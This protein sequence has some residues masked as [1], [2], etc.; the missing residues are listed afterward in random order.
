M[1]EPVLPRT[2]RVLVADDHPVVRDGTALILETEPDLRVVGQAADGEEA[3]RLA[4]ELRPEVLLL[5]LGMPRMDGVEVIRRLRET[6]PEINVVVFTVFDS[7]ERIIAALQAG[8]RG[9]LLKGARREELFDAVRTVAGGGSLL[10]PVVA[11][12]LLRHM[13]GESEEPPIEPLSERQLTVLQLVA[14]GLQNKEIA[15]RL[16]ISERTAKFH[17]ETVLR[18]LGATNRTEAAAIAT[19]RHLIEP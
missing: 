1:A 7:D 13:R 10:P 8:A 15:A 11:A 3:L 16:G 18:K 2:I 9:Y 4:E 17:V 12:R 14:R 19:R 5:D 6:R